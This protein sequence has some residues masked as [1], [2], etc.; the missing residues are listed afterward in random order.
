MT[1]CRCGHTAEH[2]ACRGKNPKMSHC[3]EQCC[4]CEEYRP[5]GSFKKRHV[6]TLLSALV[7]LGC[8]YNTTIVEPQPDAETTDADPG[9]TSLLLPDAKVDSTST[10]DAGSV[11]SGAIQEASPEA[12]DG[13]YIPSWESSQF[14]AFCGLNGSSTTPIW[15]GC[16]VAIICP[17][18]SYGGLTKGPG[19]NC[20]WGGDDIHGRTWCCP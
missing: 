12:S 8:T 20:H 5:H 16:T 15:P 10:P 6:V 17:V 3:T 18:S 1:R 2:H 14:Q 19:G 9:E 11:E 7:L 13:C 4:P